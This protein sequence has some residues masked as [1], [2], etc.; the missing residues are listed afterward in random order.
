MLPTMAYPIGMHREVALRNNSTLLVPAAVP[1]PDEFG[2]VLE[3]REGNPFPSVTKMVQALAKF[4]IDSTIAI[5]TFDKRKKNL[6][7]ADILESSVNFLLGIQTDLANWGPTSES[8]K[9][10]QAYLIES[11]QMDQIINFISKILEIVAKLR[12]GEMDEKTSTQVTNLGTAVTSLSVKLE[13]QGG[14]D[15]S[16][17]KLDELHNL[18]ITKFPEVVQQTR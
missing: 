9:K 4:T 7:I 17:Q 15:E 18:L 6:A 5:I 2:S 1:V 13:Q 16:V 12:A 3:S 8:T 14:F 10:V 11:G